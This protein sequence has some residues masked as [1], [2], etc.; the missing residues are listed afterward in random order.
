MKTKIAIFQTDLKLGGIQKS[1]INLLNAMDGK[2]YEI[3]LYLF[4]KSDFFNASIPATVNVIYL[5][6]PNQLTRFTPFSISYLITRVKIQKHY[7]TVI[8]F[9]GYQNCTA[10]HALKTKATRHIYWVHTDMYVRRNVK[11]KNILKFVYLRMLMSPSKWQRFDTFVGVSEGVLPGFKKD[12]SN[13]EFFVIPNIINSA[14]I[15]KKSVEPVDDTA[16]DPSNLNIAIVGRLERAKG[17][18]LFVN[19]LPAIVEERRDAHFFFIGDGALRDSLK[20]QVLKLGIEPQ[21]SFLGAKKNPY[22]YL[23]KMDGLVLYSRFEGQGMV[24]LEAKVLGVPQYF[25]R[26]LEKYTSGLVGTDDIVSSLVNANKKAAGS[27]NKL[28][29]YNMDIVNQID[30]LFSGRLA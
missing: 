30:G 8:D 22:K 27:L 1:L 2:S 25:P 29:E 24:L 23:S 14:E 16:I 28:S 10:I 18:D 17:L 7:D 6:K 19:L 15:I 21:V 12:F 26:H 3:D 4:S 13:K 20:H 5:K 9:N 11:L